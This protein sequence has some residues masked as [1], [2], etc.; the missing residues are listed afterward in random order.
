MRFL[1]SGQLLLDDGARD[2]LRAL[3]D[4][5][6]DAGG[7]ASIQLAHCGGFTKTGRPKGP[8]WGFNRYGALLGRPL[9]WPLDADDRQRI[10]ASFVSATHLAFDCGFDAVEVHLGHGYLFSQWLS[11]LFHPAPLEERLAWPTQVLRS[12]RHE[13][14]GAVLAKTNL[15]DGIAGGLT[16]DEGVAV[17]RAIQGDVDAI[18]PSGGL[19][20]RNA[21]FLLRGDA[22]LRDMIDV[23]KS[24]LQRLALRVFGPLVLREMEFEPRYFQADAEAVLEAVD[25][26]VVLLGGV[27][28]RGA[29][30]AA[31]EAGFE[32]VAMGRAL[33]SDPDFVRRLEAGEDVVARCDRCNRCMAE[34]D[35]DGV[36][37]VQ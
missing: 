28:S 1:Q 15:E 26:P 33:L 20:Q 10:E 11:P 24:A 4:A 22:P 14:T 8:T 32:F 3:C 21:L 7:A 5:V 27:E 34:M 35:R 6:H 29:I 18:L 36:R 30:D 19:V 9:V 25:V 13:A 2:G 17:A 23:E 37:C 31:M 12:V 16:L